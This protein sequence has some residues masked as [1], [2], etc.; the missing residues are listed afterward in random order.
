[1]EIVDQ[2]RDLSIRIRGEIVRGSNYYNHTTAA[3]RV[4]QTVV[5]EGRAIQ[6]RDK[7]TGD[8]TDGRGLAASAQGYVTEYLSESVFQNHVTL[9][10]DY[11]F[12]L[13]GAWLT[14]YPRGIVGLG[15]D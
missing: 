13:I 3:W 2:I 7:I 6:V 15:E 4:L 11:V 12:G 9:F 5:A 1:M 14:A 10:E 8:V